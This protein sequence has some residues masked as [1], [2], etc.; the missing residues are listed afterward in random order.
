MTNTD[1]RAVSYK[2]RIIK[3]E[4]EKRDRAEDIKEVMLEAKG[5]GLIKEELAGIK[6]AVRRYFETE[7]RRKFR[8]SAEE[9]ASALGEFKDLPLGAAAVQRH[10]FDG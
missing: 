3:L 2:D 7:D 5:S 6:L 8:E 10:S 1:A 4:Q 9:F